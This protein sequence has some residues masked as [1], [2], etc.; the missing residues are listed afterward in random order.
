MAKKTSIKIK[1]FSNKEI[2][3]IINDSGIPK[4]ITEKIQKATRS[5]VFADDGS[6]IPALKDVTIDWR[7]T[8]EDPNRTHS[9]YSAEKSNLTFTGELLDSI[10][11]RV[12][13]KSG[14]VEI[15]NF[16]DPKRNHRP[17]KNLDGKPMG[18]RV[19]MTAIAEGQAKMG[20]NFMRIPKDTVK[21][22][23]K[24]LVKELTKRFNKKQ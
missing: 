20:R 8:Y 21:E 14:K 6:K 13:T 4:Q 2:K 17:Y 19:P 22:L 23:Q 11:S 24:V 9:D 7:E 10:K 3:D 12:T 18:K 5:G 16:V 15:T 1:K